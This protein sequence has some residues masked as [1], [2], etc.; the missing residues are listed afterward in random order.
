MFQGGGAGQAKLGVYNLTTGE[1]IAMVDLAASIANAPG[2][3]VY[4]ANDVTVG[5]DGTVYVTDMRMNVV[6]QVD[7][8]YQASVLHRFDGFAPNGIVYH[9]SGYLLVAGGA[10]L[11]KV[12]LDDPAAAMQ[13][14][15]PE[16]V[17]GQDGMVWTADGRLAIVSNSGNRVVA[18]T[19]EDDWATAQLA[20]VATYEIQGTTAAVVGDDVY[21]VH[22]HFADEDPPSV[23]R[24]TFR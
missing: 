10:T 12:P 6:Y 1:R 13:V 18:L 14:M 4:F 19:S 16:E 9:S 20:G 8:N 15:L 5:D 11:W 2:D 24:V 23:E 3:A 7:S 22:P 17:P 21:V